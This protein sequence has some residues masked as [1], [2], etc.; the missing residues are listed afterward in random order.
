MLSTDGP[1]GPFVVVCDGMGGAAGG[2]V[3]SDLAARA[4]WSELVE[5]QATDDPEVFARLLRR[6]VRVAN[7]RVWAEGRREPERVYPLLGGPDLAETPAFRAVAARHDEMLQSYR[8]RAWDERPAS[9]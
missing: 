6:G 3:A 5:A 7:Q 8:R 1:R 2:D 9:H 4:A